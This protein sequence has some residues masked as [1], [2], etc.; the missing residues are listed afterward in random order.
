MPLL[1]I[2]PWWGCCKATSEYLYYITVLHLYMHYNNIQIKHAIEH[3]TSMQ[4]RCYV[5]MGIINNYVHK[6][7]AN[8]IKDDYTYIR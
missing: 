4:N 7:M 2:N 3:V 6:I 8:T 5:V 1:N